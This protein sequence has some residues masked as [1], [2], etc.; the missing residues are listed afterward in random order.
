MNADI[1]YK[2]FLRFK[3]FGYV[4][5]KGQA[6][7][8]II[9]KRA[10]RYFVSFVFEVEQADTVSC[11]KSAG[12]GID[13]GI[14]SFAVVSEGREYQ[15]IN[16]SRWMR[17]LTKRLKYEQR[18]FMRKIRHRK[19]D[20]AAKKCKR[21]NLDKQRL[22]VQRAYMR[23]SN[24]RHDYINDM[25]APNHLSRLAKRG[26]VERGIIKEVYKNTELHFFCSR[27]THVTF[28]MDQRVRNDSP[29]DS[30]GRGYTQPRQRQH[31]RLQKTPC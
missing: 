4:P 26:Q 1:V 8:V 9:T 7:S 16:K 22:K 20:T 14:K 15:N 19:E 3:E 6:L 12:I 17:K 21:S 18:K 24:K 10:G 28:T 25:Q 27:N 29:A 13:L 23:L 31:S 5:L 30:F 2:N 11:E